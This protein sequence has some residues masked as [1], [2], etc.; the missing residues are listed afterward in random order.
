MFG[1][2]LFDKYKELNPPSKIVFVKHAH[3]ISIYLYPDTK[4][5]NAKSK[6]KINIT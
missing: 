2:F 5:E 3:A 4:T 6:N 1:V